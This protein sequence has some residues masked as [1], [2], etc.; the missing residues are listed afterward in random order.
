MGQVPPDAAFQ[1]WQIVDESVR[2]ARLA[3]MQPHRGARWRYDAGSRNHV[4]G[5]DLGKLLVVTRTMDAPVALECALALVAG[6]CAE[7]HRAHEQVGPGGARCIE[8]S[9]ARVWIGLD[10]VIQ[11]VGAPS[12]R[13][14]RE[15]GALDEA[16]YR[17]PEQSAGRTLDRRSD[18]FSLG[19]MLYEL[20][21]GQLP[22]GGVGG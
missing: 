16:A 9:P 6:A 15:P 11:L 8:V 5:E 17:S 21:T 14:E 13:A 1:G 10:G 12:E 18:V 3:A 19:V 4:N 22:F 20:T 2:E 7:V